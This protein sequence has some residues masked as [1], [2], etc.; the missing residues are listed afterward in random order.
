MTILEQTDNNNT[1]SNKTVITSNGKY[2]TLNN[3]S[4]LDQQYYACYYET[5]NETEFISVFYLIVRSKYITF[6]LNIN[7]SKS[8]SI[9]DHCPYLEIR[10]FSDMIY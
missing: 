5:Q 1:I 9:N 10:N 2:L 8:D 4:L 6:F 7:Q 3:V